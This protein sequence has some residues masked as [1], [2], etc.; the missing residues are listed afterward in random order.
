MVKKLLRGL[1]LVVYY[2]YKAASW[3]VFSLF[4]LFGL[5]VVAVALYVNSHTSLLTASVD[6]KFEGEKYLYLNIEDVTEKS[7]ST[8]AYYNLAIN[9]GLDVPSQVSITDLVEVIEDAAKDDRIKGLI[10]D[11]DKSN[12]ETFGMH[13]ELD[14]AIQKFKKDSEGK[15]PVYGYSVYYSLGD[16][17]ALQNADK[18]IVDAVGSYSADFVAASFFYKDFYKTYGIKD[19]SFQVGK[20]GLAALTSQDG[21]T[22]ENLVSIDSI[23]WKPFQYALDTLNA[24]RT[25]VHPDRPLKLDAK[26]ESDTA[27]QIEDAYT[28]KSD[29]VLYKDY[30]LFDE[31]FTRFQ[32]GDFVRKQAGVDK[33]TK[34]PKVVYLDEYLADKRVRAAEDKTDYSTKDYYLNYYYGGLFGKDADVDPNEIA[35]ELLSLTVNAKEPE[36]D[37]KEGKLKGIVLRLDSL[38]GTLGDAQVLYSALRKV[39]ESGVPVVVLTGDGLVGSAYVAAT[40]ADAIVS[41]KYVPVGA[42]NASS[43]LIDTTDTLRAFYNM[44][45]SYFR[46]TQLI[47]PGGALP[48]PFNLVVKGGGVLVSPQFVEYRKVVTEGQYEDSLALV[49]KARKFDEQKLAQVDQGR[50]FTG[51][52]AY[53]LKLVDQLG[54]VETAYELL[55]KLNKEKDEKFDAKAIMHYEANPDEG[56]YSSLL[57]TINSEIGAYQDYR[58]R[59]ELGLSETAYKVLK[60]EMKNEGQV[61]SL[62][63]LCLT[64][65]AKNVDPYTQSKLANT[66]SFLGNALYR[67]SK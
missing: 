51:Q 67:L 24:K 16:L 35:G 2:V 33:D 44:N 63:S 25:A 40:G 54:G 23:V 4:A 15:K 20:Y 45:P 66:G 11:V 3:V 52:E 22:P 55:D 5:L 37:S 53:D 18:I 9:L 30:G 58:T 13:E 61:L 17:I 1:W 65:T 34:S 26:K 19:Y 29:A 47:V 46:G 38:G 59:L 12:F 28:L 62:C 41:S 27:K 36:K 14:R 42:L 57:S 50:V 31:V 43:T 48:F 32:Y 49:A 6:E 64:P 39:S 56:P 7:I 8:P 21:F 10:I 60:F